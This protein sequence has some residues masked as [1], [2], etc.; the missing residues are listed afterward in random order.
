MTKKVAVF[1]LDTDMRS[2]TGET[3]HDNPIAYVSVVTEE[4][5][6]FAVSESF[7]NDSRTMREFYSLFERYVSDL[8]LDIDPN[9]KM[10][11][12]VVRTGLEAVRQAF[13]F[14]HDAKVDI[15]SVWNLHFEGSIISNKAE[16]VGYDLGKLLGDKNFD[17][18]KAASYRPGLAHRKSSN[19]KTVPIAIQNRKATLNLVGDFTIHNTLYYY[20]ALRPD[21]KQETYTLDNIMKVELGFKNPIREM[22][23]DLKSRAWFVALQENHPSYAY[24]ESIIP[25]MALLAFEKKSKDLSEKR[26]PFEAERSRLLAERK[27]VEK[28]YIHPVVLDML[29]QRFNQTL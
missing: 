22:M 29:N 23:P 5:V 17:G 12:R 20:T 8:G 3:M 7:Y 26:E 16:Y 4:E 14:M 13:Q 25:S 19:D 10:D 15:V 24:L 18:E 9:I 11:F 27:E 21:E 2:K 28:P 1:S 6:F